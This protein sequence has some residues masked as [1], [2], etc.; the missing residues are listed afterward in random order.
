M[1]VGTIVSKKLVDDIYLDSEALDSIYDSRIAQLPPEER[2]KALRFGLAVT[3]DEMYGWRTWTQSLVEMLWTH[4]SMS[5]SRVVGWDI[6]AYDLPVLRSCAQSDAPVQALDLSVEI[7]AAT[8]RRYKLD[9]V[10]RSNVGHGRI[11]ETQIVIDWLRSGKADAMTKATEHCQNNVQLVRDLM[12]LIHREQPLLL[13][14]RLQPDD[15]ETGWFKTKEA[16]LRVYFTPQ[17]EWMRC[18]DLR[19]KLISERA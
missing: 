17:G 1:V 3:Y 7:E 5:N 12:E 13:P 11:Q 15:E 10:T 9:T 2:L 8:Q 16:T 14:G 18:E 19:G 6:L 4:L